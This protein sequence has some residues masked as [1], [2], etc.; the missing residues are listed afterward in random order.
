MDL[1]LEI[2]H[3][4]YITRKKTTIININHIANFEFLPVAALREFFV[5][6]KISVITIVRLNRG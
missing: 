2:L 6:E 3:G 5:D 4:H 1:G